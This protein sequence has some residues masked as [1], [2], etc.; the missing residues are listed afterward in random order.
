[1]VVTIGIV[2]QGFDRPGYQLTAAQGNI[3]IAADVHYQAVLSDYLKTMTS[4]PE[5]SLVVTR[6]DAATTFLLPF[7]INM[8]IVP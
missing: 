6:R 8:M 4:I 5:S 2:I 7:K 1:M 3:P